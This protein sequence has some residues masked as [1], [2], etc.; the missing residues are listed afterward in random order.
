MVKGERYSLQ[1][2]QIRVRRRILG[3]YRMGRVR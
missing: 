1:R 3:V 2:R